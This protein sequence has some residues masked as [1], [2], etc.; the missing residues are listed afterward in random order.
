MRVSSLKHTKIVATIGPA[1][2]S[3]EVLENLML[4]GVNAFRLNLS[5]GTHEQHGQVVKTARALSA[6]H[7]RPIAVIGDLQGPKIRVGT[8]P[9]DG[10]PFVRDN[11]V[12]FQFGADY[13]RTGIIPVQHDVSK[14]LKK[15]ERIFLRDGTIQVEVQKVEKSLITA[16]I[17]NPGL[18]YSNQGMNLPDSDMGGDILTPK[19]IADIEFCVQAQT[20]YIALSFVQTA[21]DILDLK[22]RLKKLKS[23]VRVIAKIE[24]AAAVENLEEIVVATDALMVARGDLAVE[25][26]P[27]AV[28]AVQRRMIELAKYHRKTII[29]ATQMLESM[30]QS[31]Q[32]TRAEVSDVATAVLEGTDAVMLSGETA[33]GLFPVETVQMMK[34]IIM[35]AEHEERFVSSYAPGLI[36]VQEPANAISAAAVLLAG[37]LPAKAIIAETSSGQTARNISSL[38][39][40]APIIIV[41]DHER[42]YHQMA[43]VWGGK[44]FLAD[45]MD[46]AAD[47]VVRELKTLGMVAKGDALVHAS[48]NQPGLI[49]GTNKIA[50]KVVD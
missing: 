35:S 14:Y 48:G 1:S 50:I 7:K 8:L 13:D 49:G 17:M 16:K 23:D 21:N 27:E 20:D 30:I 33:T 12:R 36:D 28:P 37:Q 4:A 22:E 40:D 47:H 3:P 18:L 11:L 44:A 15:G 39:P 42:V 9:A 45:S 24:T 26:K 29:V 46:H 38:R 41:T 32:P 25:T 19:D 43:I 10:L 2:S 31:P 5:H 34:R 6:K